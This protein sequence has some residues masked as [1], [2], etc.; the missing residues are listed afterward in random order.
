MRLSRGGAASGYLG[1][2]FVTLQVF[3]FLLQQYFFRKAPAERAVLSLSHQRR[4]WR[5]PR[6][7]GFPRDLMDFGPQQL[8]ERFRRFVSENTECKRAANVQD[9]QCLL[10]YWIWTCLLRHVE[11]LY[12]FKGRNS[13]SVN[14]NNPTKIDFKTY[15]LMKVILACFMDFACLENCDPCDYFKIYFGRSD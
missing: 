4:F 13:A 12:T 6:K 2:S 5:H 14:S 10:R 15:I 7:S 8:P 3:L 9:T 1:L 11:V